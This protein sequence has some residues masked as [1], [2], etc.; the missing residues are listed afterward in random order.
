[1]LVDTIIQVSGLSKVYSGSNVVALKNVSLEIRRGEI[2]ALLGRNGAGKSTLINVVCGILKPTAG[3]IRIDDGDVHR[4]PRLTRAAVGLMPQELVV[5]CHQ[6]IWQSVK[7]SRGL[8]GKPPNDRHLE[9]VLRDLVLW[10]KRNSKLMTL[11]GG[12]KRRVMIAKALAHEP[13]VLFLDEPTAGV[14]LELRHTLWG[15][16]NSLRETG[17][18]IVLTTH[19]IEEAE[20]MADRVGVMRD[21]ELIL[22]KDKTALMEELG[23]KTLILRLRH[24]LAHVPCE[25]QGTGWRLSADGLALELSMRARDGGQDIAD[26]LRG[27]ALCSVSITDI[28]TVKTSLQEVY[29]ELL[30]QPR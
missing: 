14:D 9:G 21:G 26:L 27:M 6:T 12:M 7:F 13:K 16:V 5:D 17:V 29:V 30:R 23:R 25:L 22:V 4:K 28:D 18:T 8:F 24:P 20:E 19:Y 15:V 3:S 2:F 1:M 11:S 10:D